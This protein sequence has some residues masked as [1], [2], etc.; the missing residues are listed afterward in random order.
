[1]NN[2]IIEQ[3]NTLNAYVAIQH[4]EITTK[5]KTRQIN[6]CSFMEL[7]VEFWGEN[8]AKFKILQS[9]HNRYNQMHFSKTFDKVSDTLILYKIITFE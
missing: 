1:M 5:Q 3:L 2:K 6:S 4:T 7:Y 8:F 9:E